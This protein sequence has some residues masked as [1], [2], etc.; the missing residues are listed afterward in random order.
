VHPQVGLA[1]FFIDLAV[2]DPTNPAC[3]LLGI[4]C[5]GAN[6][7]ALRSARDRD[8]LRQQV[9]EDRGWTIHRIW[10]T[11]WFN[12]PEEQLRRVVGVIEETLAKQSGQ[13]QVSKKAPEML[14]S[15][16]RVEILRLKRPKGGNDKALTSAK[17]VEASPRIRR[18][19]QIHEV[20]VE[21]LATIVIK[22][23]AVEGPIH[24]D[25]ITRRIASLWGLARVGSRTVDAVE[26]ALT[27]ASQREEIE[28]DG[29]F[30][31][32]AGQIE[33]QIRDR[34]NVS[35]ANL[36]KPEYLP[37]SEIRVALREVVDAHCGMTVDEAI[38]ETARLLGFRRTGE[39][40][41]TVI[42]DEVDYLID[43]HQLSSRNE[44]LYSP[45]ADTEKDRR[46][47][48]KG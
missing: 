20:Q 1:G 42:D 21:K 28:Q 38:V 35:S 11:D 13:A 15:P 45:S 41:K 47:V 29:L 8:R 32:P 7:H 3:Y 33:P 44:N 16:Q 30:Y 31:S 46:S 9:L 2:V 40:L 26:R 43:N 19:Q 22:I 12:R 27:E 14:P 48:L 4:E 5:D 23:V 10:S 25:E 39:Q 17:Y 24:Q 6:Y 36:L 34:S 18:T 37:P